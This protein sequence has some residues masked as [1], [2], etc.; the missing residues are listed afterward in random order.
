MKIY[1]ILIYW[2]CT[3]VISGFLL[4]VPW[5]YDLVSKKIKI[6]RTQPM[7]PKIIGKVDAGYHLVFL[8]PDPFEIPIKKSYR[9][10][11]LTF[12]TESESSFYKDTIRCSPQVNWPRALA[13]VAVLLL[14]QFTTLFTTKLVNTKNIK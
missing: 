13:P 1:S 11:E 4:Y 14:I 8:P 3:F 6:V 5:E 10:E 2:L 12:L 9:T 7:H